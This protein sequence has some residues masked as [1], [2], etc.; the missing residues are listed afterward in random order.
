MVGAVMELMR[1][2]SES[3]VG[4]DGITYNVRYLLTQDEWYALRRAGLIDAP[5]EVIGLAPVA[6]LLVTQL[7]KNLYEAA[8]GVVQ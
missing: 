6:D 4:S 3:R 8:G 7:E 5:S 2:Y 1:A